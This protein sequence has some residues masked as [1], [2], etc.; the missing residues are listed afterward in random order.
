MFRPDYLGRQGSEKG[1]NRALFGLS[2]ELGV[3]GGV[4]TG[5][6]YPCVCVRPDV[7]VCVCVPGVDFS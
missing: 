1:H 3:G 6:G 2:T 5:S 7:C 4:L